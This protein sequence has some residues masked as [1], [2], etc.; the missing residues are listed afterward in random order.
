MQLLVPKPNQQVKAKVKV[1]WKQVSRVN[2]Y[3]RNKIKH[4]NKT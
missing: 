4:T 2:E 3:Q 1:G